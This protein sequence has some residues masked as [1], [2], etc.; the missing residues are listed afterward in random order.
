M[1]ARPENANQPNPLMKFLPVIIIVIGAAIA[2]YFFFSGGSK[3]ATTAPSSAAGGTTAPAAGAAA[4]T[5][6]AP[7]LTKEQLIKEAGTASREQR[8]VSPAG[9]NA[10]EF[11][12]R[13]LDKEPNNLT[14]KEALR[15]TFPIAVGSV[16]QTINSGNIE[17]AGRE[18]DLL[19]KADPANYTLT[20]LRSK[21]DAKKKQV[22]NEQKVASAAAA[23]AA[24]PAQNAQTAPA[25]APPPEQ[26]AA[27]PAQTP[28]TAAATPAPPPVPAAPK[29]A[30]AP[31]PPPVTETAAAPAAGGETHPAELIKSVPP[32][33]PPD[34][35]RSR[36]QGWVEVEFTVAPDGSVSGAQ[37]VSSEP[38]RI[39]NAAALNAVKRWTFK[40]RMENGKAVEERMRRRIEFRL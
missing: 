16:E 30:P 15:E 20:I 10:V 38:A 5:A 28:A 33:Y 31:A 1:P 26:P 29:P 18:I 3:P 27:T 4:P 35:Y 14:A 39:F 11:Y 17:E 36:A 9:N 34:A 40:P 6:P 12:L 22:E 25:P 24:Q 13:V 2:A 37:V 7:E 21:L 8:Y 23:K 19:A 32:D